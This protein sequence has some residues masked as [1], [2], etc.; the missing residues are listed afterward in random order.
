MNIRVIRVQG[1]TSESGSPTASRVVRPL[2]IE[3]G[4]C[5][6]ISRI[7]TD[8]AE[9]PPNSSAPSVSIRGIRVQGWLSGNGLTT[10]D[11]VGEPDRTLSG[12]PERAGPVHGCSRIARIARKKPEW[13]RAIR[14]HP[15][16][17]C[18]EPAVRIRFA[19][20]LNLCLHTSRS[21]D[22]N[23]HTDPASVIETQFGRGGAS[24]KLR[25]S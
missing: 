13:L 24:A 6:R 1:Q 8:H 21:P 25:L 11:A 14:E 20:S 3:A 9:S 18:T 23:R 2:Y 5:T 17:P 4:S 7:V 19:N 16:D 22:G 10:C 15:Y 12:A